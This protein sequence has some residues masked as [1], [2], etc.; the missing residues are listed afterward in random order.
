MNVFLRHG[1]HLDAARRTWPAA[2]EPWLDLSTGLNPQ[3]YDAPRASDAQRARLPLTTDLHALRDAAAAAFDVDDPTRVFTVAGA[4]TALRALPLLGLGTSVALDPLLYAS[5]EAAWRAAGAQIVAPDEEADIR[6]LINP[7][8]PTGAITNVATIRDI[9]DRQ[10]ARGGW[11]VIDESFAD[12]DPEVSVALWPHPRLIVLRSFGKFFGL[13]GLRLGFVVTDP[14]LRE[15][16]H[17]LCG[18]WPV[19]ADA[20][21][22]GT[23]AYRD[24]VWIQQTRQRL[25]DDALRLDGL[26]RQAGFDIVGGTNLFRLTRSPD[27]ALRFE[28]L[29]EQ[30]ILTRPF[31]Q[32][33]D[34]IRFGLPP[35]DSWGRLATSLER[36]A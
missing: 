8:N 4:E 20:I 30:G 25:A 36:L 31:P 1:G 23:Q 14:S 33:P 26:L 34:W 3:P 29:A 15:R 7:A 9:A 27:A 2:P 12:A 35:A 5:H 19:S 32:R 16:I 24:Q 22:A 21:V 13:A 6:I 28:Q 11:L 17:A 10:A 18:D